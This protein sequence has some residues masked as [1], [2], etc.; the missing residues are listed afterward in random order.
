MINIIAGRGQIVPHLKHKHF[1]TIAERKRIIEITLITY[2]C[3]LIKSPSIT[4]KLAVLKTDPLISSIRYN[5]FIIIILPQ[6]K[7]K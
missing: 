4:R 1:N 7:L 3:S 5:V 6:D 2:E